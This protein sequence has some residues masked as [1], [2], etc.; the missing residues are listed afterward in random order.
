MIGAKAACMVVISP[1]ICADVI[2]YCF[3]SHHFLFAYGTF[4]ELALNDPDNLQAEAI[5][6]NPHVNFMACS[7]PLNKGIDSCFAA[8]RSE[9]KSGLF[10]IFLPIGCHITS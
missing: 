10:L 1:A 2:D 8:Q 6:A 7:C 5:E 3:Q 4:P 9:E